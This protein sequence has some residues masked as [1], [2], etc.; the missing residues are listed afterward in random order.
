MLESLQ[1]KTEAS[2]LVTELAMHILAEE[3]DVLSKLGYIQRAVEYAKDGVV[4]EDANKLHRLML[5]PDTAK[6]FA[7]ATYS[8]HDGS[9]RSVSAENT[10][11]QLNAVMSYVAASGLVYAHSYLEFVLEILLQMTR[12][13]DIAP[14][15]SFIGNKDVSISAIVKDELEPAIETKLK[16][17]IASLHKE[18]LLKKVDYL[19][20]VLECSIS[21]STVRDYTYDSERL[22]RIDTLRHDLSHHR[23]KD[24]GIEAAEADITYVYQSAFHFL[25]VVVHRYDLRGAHRPKCK[26]S[27]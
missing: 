27:G 3:S 15:L 1:N 23:K 21:K 14:W 4:I 20:K 24:Y 18:G 25:D 2:Y 12:L 5:E 8:V 22:K 16:Q 17:F 11:T 26:A 13:C 7:G 6:Y 9:Y 10:E 19:A